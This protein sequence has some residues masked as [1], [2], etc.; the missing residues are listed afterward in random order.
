M[1]RYNSLSIVSG[2]LLL[3]FA[4]GIGLGQVARNMDVTTASGP[5]KYIAKVP[6]NASTLPVRAAASLAG[7]RLTYPAGAKSSRA[8]FA[9][10]ASPA[11]GA[12]R[13]RPIRVPNNDGDQDD[14]RSGGNIPGLVTVPTFAGAFAAQGAEDTGIVF[15]Y[16]MV[17]NHPL[18]GGTTTVPAYITA[19]SLQLLN[20]DGSVR[21]DVPYAPFEELT[22]NSPNFQN[23]DYTSGRG[24]QFTDAVQRAEFFHSMQSDWHTRL[25]PQIVDR[26]TLQI[27]RF[28]QVEFPDNTVKTIQ[29]YYLG[30]APDGSFFLELLDLLFN[31]VNDDLAVNEIVNNNFQTYAE[32]ANVYPNTFLFSIDDTGKKSDCC[33]LGFHTYYFEDAVVPQPRILFTFA[34]WVSPGIFGGGFQDITPL[35]H[36]ISE[37]FNDPF[38]DT[39]VPAWQFPGVPANA[40]VCQGNLEDGDPVEVLDNIAFPVTIYLDRRRPFTFHPQTEALLQWFEMGST[41]D[42]IGGA[43][44]YPNTATLPKSALPCPPKPAP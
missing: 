39:A 19:V 6:V 12:D 2:P 17:G 20:P 35:S 41:S 37:T 30:R 33:V 14:E 1:N 32:N 34:S 16:V 4:A 13:T 36:E 43:F 18:R 25:E 15:P 27:P 26:V 10:S 8:I 9:A 24:I 42:A 44:S 7:I 29:A 40:R 3:L 38:V 21:A 31:A 22:L 28:V 23:A 11:T 5:V